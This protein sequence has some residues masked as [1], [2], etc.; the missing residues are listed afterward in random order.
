MHMQGITAQYAETK[1][2]DTHIYIQLHMT[3]PHVSTLACAYIPTY[4][5]CTCTHNI[6]LNISMQ[7]YV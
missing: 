7:T 6:T 3:Y 1:M 4:T 2:F 5:L